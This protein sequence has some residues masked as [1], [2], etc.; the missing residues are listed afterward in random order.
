[1]WAAGSDA[2]AE[3]YSA[4][5]SG[6]DDDDDVVG[7]A[8]AR[9]AR[10]GTLVHVG[11]A[12]AWHEDPFESASYIGDSATDRFTS[13]VASKGFGPCGTSGGVT[14]RHTLMES[15]VSAAF[16]GSLLVWHLRV[17][18][19][20]VWSFLCCT[21]T[22]RCLVFLV[23]TLHTIWGAASGSGRCLSRLWQIN[24]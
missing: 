19:H 8:C 18:A 1:M 21:R 5:E 22:T 13:A 4:N 3:D 20:A 15:T 24:A 14:W 6:A 12:E 23:H 9:G 10:S 11:Y 2:G 7:G 17:R 16:V